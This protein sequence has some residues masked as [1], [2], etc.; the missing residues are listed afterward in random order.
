MSWV[1]FYPPAC[2]V[3]QHRSDKQAMHA[4]CAR[5][6]RWKRPVFKREV[7]F[8]PFT[9]L[10]HSIMSERGARTS[11]AIGPSGTEHQSG[12]GV[13]QQTI[14]EMLQEKE[15]PPVRLLQCARST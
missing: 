1:A 14:H 4:A 13:P 10:K 9:A 15:A 8:I 11:A 12:E 3:S 6:K 2:T 5:M 7:F